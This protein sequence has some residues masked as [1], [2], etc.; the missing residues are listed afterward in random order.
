MIEKIITTEMDAVIHL[1]VNG[2]NLKV[3]GRTQSLLRKPFITRMRNILFLI[4]LFT[5]Q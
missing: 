3:D 2:D 4:L 1:Q 5:I